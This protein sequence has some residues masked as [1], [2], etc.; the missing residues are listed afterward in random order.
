MRV[1]SL[2][3]GNRPKEISD[4]LRDSMLN[5]L[6]AGFDSET[7]N[8]LESFG[9]KQLEERLTELPDAFRE[10]WGIS[11]G[12]QERVAVLLINE[13]SGNPKAKARQRTRVVAG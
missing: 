12:Y 5:V 4:T 7:G 1:V 3:E 11:T 10:K 6:D 2:N 13:F 9:L 8:Y